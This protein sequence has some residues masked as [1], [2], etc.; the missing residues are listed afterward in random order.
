MM[1]HLLVSIAADFLILGKLPKS[2]LGSLRRGALL[3]L[4][5]FIALTNGIFSCA[6]KLRIILCLHMTGQEC[7][8]AK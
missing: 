1:T 3:A 5:F 2:N 6:A 7:E 4:T 8:V